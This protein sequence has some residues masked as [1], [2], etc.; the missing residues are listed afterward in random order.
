MSFFIKKN[1]SVIRVIYS[2]TQSS[3]CMVTWA[4]DTQP[5]KKI[6]EKLDHLRVNHKEV[7]HEDRP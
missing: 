6:N 5:Q 4:P 7:V 3:N 2:V 1:L